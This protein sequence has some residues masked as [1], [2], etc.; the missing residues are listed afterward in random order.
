MTIDNWGGAALLFL[1]CASFESL[2]CLSVNDCCFRN[3]PICFRYGLS[4]C[5]VAYN[6]WHQHEYEPM[7]ARTVRF[8]NTYFQ[9]VLSEWHSLD[10]N[11][12]ESETIS[13][14]IDH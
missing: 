11:I 14:F 3:H 10:K 1:E 9:N 4:L 5:P 13:K 7:A 6:L 2:R 12:N 8:S